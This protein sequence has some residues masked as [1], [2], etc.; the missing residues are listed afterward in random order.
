MPVQQ[1]ILLG[2]PTLSSLRLGASVVIIAN[3][4][5]KDKVTDARTLRLMEER[6]SLGAA[7]ASLGGKWEQTLT[8]RV[9]GGDLT[10]ALWIAG[11][12][13]G[14]GERV[15]ISHFSSETLVKLNTCLSM[16]IPGESYACNHVLS[17]SNYTPR[18]SVL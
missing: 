9:N 18:L 13:E 3:T 15:S 7:V 11:D 12:E 10:H 17:Y 14:G 1:V 2:M 4:S 5:K 8:D 16:N 6:E